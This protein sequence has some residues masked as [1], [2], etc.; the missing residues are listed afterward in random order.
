MT[1]PPR[2]LTALIHLMGMLVPSLAARIA[3]GLFW[4]L[5]RAAAV[6]QRDSAVHERAARSS[7]EL[8][9]EK[10]AVY[11]WGDGPTAIL[12]VHGWRSRAST[13]ATVV[14]A[15]ERSDRTIIAFDAPGNGDSD[16]HRTTLYDYAAIIRILSERHGRLD[17]IVGHSF[18]VLATFYAVR[19]GVHT[20]RI[21]SIAGVHSFETVLATFAAAIHLPGRALRILRRRIER[22]LLDGDATRWRTFVSELEPTDVT[23]PVLV[24]HD[25]GDAAVPVSEGERIASAHNGPTELV[26]TT[27]LGHS[28]ILGDPAVL[29]RIAEFVTSP[30]RTR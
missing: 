1:P 27:G 15:L 26:I 29:Q 7:L 20:D 12:L 17:T 21:V 3:N 23:T 9:G 13:F 2:L 4:D 14:A 16:G 24:I 11:A 28:R 19:G 6:N 5:G 25:S 22:T 10:V 30:A 18:G 8:N